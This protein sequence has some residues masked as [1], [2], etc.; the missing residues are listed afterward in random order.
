MSYRQ[1]Q[2]LPL[3]RL[4]AN[5]AV[6][7]VVVVAGFTA[8]TLGLTAWFSYQ[9]YRAVYLEHQHAKV[10]I[11]AQFVA[12]ISP[13]R[14]FS[15][16]FV[17]LHSYVRELSKTRDLTYAYVVDN[18]GEPLTAYLDKT[19]PLVMTAIRAAGSE[20]IRKVVAQINQLPE[21]FSVSAPI[22]FNHESIGSVTIGATRRFVDDELDRIL[23]W[24]AVAGIALVVLLSLGIFLVFRHNILAPTQHLIAG[25]RRV[26]RG[27]LREPIPVASPDEL[28]QLAGSFNEMMHDLDQSNNERA[29]ALDELRDLNRTLEIRVEERTRAIEIVN[30]E[31]ERLALYDALT[32]LPNRTLFQD[33]LEH[34]LKTAEREPE[35]FAVM[36]MDLDR[37]KEVNDTFGHHTGDQ[38]LNQLGHR[39]V[40]TLRDTDTIGRLGGDEFAV[41]LP[42][43]N[44]ESAVRVAHKIFE[45]LKQPVQLETMSLMVSAS[46]GIAIYP[47]HGSDASTLLKHA[48]IAMYQAKQS[49]SGHCIYDKELDTHSPRRMT[50]MNDIR[51]A[52]DAG[53]MQLY[54]QPIVALR[55]GT[56]RGVEALARWTHPEK[57]PIPPDQF[58]PMIEQTGLIKAFSHWVIDTALRQWSI[59]NAR[60]INEAVSVN[61]SML[62][63]QDREFPAALA[64]LLTKWS[65]PP[66]ALMLEVTESAMMSD[67][68]HALD[69]LNHFQSLGVDISIDDFGTGYSSLSHLKRLPVNEIKID[70]AFVKDMRYDKDDEV[71]VRSTIELAH[72]LGLMVVAEGVEDVE[73]LNLLADLNCD[74][75]QGFYFGRPFPAERLHLIGEPQ[76][77]RPILEVKRS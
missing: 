33:R 43:T 56:V 42:A 22:L 14:I 67:P 3:H 32:H 4:R 77:V 44:R 34:V 58:I 19:D 1:P 21:V 55:N 66:H 51:G 31:L 45:T 9:S 54:Y 53:Q 39:L 11:L 74:L 76:L 50:L 40:A 46:L 23:F 57:G 73:T 29:K 62:N 38:L 37:F 72:N 70:R 28:G 17:S 18:K 5:L 25:A 13:D 75:A 16:D 71:I 61:L 27:E 48:D 2:G 68:E 49:K 63:L 41:V 12:S 60:G 15:Y 30:I 10:V 26:A 65:V 36:L 47:E 59:W 64:Q 8:L 35:P 24:N 69:T 6:K 52:I 20:D 7:F